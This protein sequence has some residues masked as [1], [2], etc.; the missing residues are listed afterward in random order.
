MKGE[1]G[2]ASRPISSFSYKIRDYYAVTRALASMLED[3][4]A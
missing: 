4:V 1:V 3:A 2:L